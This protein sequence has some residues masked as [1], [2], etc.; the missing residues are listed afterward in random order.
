[1][2][3]PQSARPAPRRA[4]APDRRPPLRPVP[5]SRPAPDPRATP[6]TSPA[7]RPVGVVGT[8]LAVV[9]FCTF[10]GLAALHA[11]QVQTQA[12]IDTLETAN[13]ARS[14][15]LD[16]LE[17]RLAHLDSPVGVAEAARTAG[18]VPASEVAPLVPV[19]PGALPPPSPEV[20]ARTSF[21]GTG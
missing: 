15:Y 20:D 4:P 1:M 3:S 19:A 16:E 12:R 21:G 11:L 8:V 17:V 14:A 9:V 10:F 2:A 13:A 18:L 6:R 7:R 5:R